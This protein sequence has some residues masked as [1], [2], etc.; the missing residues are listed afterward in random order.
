MIRSARHTEAVTIDIQQQRSFSAAVGEEIRVLLT[1]RRKSGRQL[2]QELN[3]SQTWLS[4]RLIG[5]TPID[6][7]DLARIAAALD[8][9]PAILLERA[10]QPTR[11]YH[12]ISP[13]DPH[14]VDA[15]SPRHRGT[16]GTGTHSGSRTE[17]ARRVHPGSYRGLGLQDQFLQ[18]AA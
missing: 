1:R 16:S 9:E 13:V 2:A 11:P 17:R 10:A 3:V 5:T 4:S 18:D 8:V 15:R 14:P 7:N 6:L 12:G